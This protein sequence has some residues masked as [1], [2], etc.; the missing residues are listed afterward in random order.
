MDSKQFIQCAE[1]DAMV[2]D[3]LHQAL[4]AMALTSGCTINQGGV[5]GTLRF[6][7]EIAKLRVA[8]YVL[9]I[10]TT[11]QLPAPYRR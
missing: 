1:R 7:Q 2:I 8:L 5:S 9:G 10:D 6:E 3:A 11:Q 4:Y